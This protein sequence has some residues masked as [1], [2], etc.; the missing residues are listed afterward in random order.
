M[1]NA[2]ISLVNHTMKKTRSSKTI[3]NHQQQQQNDQNTLQANMNQDC[4]EN[5]DDDI[6]YIRKEV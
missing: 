5:I 1:I 4:L 2:K 3:H 6:L